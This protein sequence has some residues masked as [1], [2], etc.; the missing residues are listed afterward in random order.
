M[1]DK[2]QI[3]SRLENRSAQMRLI[4]IALFA[5]FAMAITACGSDDDDPAGTPTPEDTPVA[6]DDGTSPDPCQLVRA[7]DVQDALDAVIARPEPERV[8][9]LRSC[10]YTREDGL[11]NVRIQTMVTTEEAF[12]ELIRDS[13][14]IL[15]VEAD[16]VPA[17]G[18]ESYFLGSTLLT[19]KGTTH[20]QILPETEDRDRQVARQLMER[21]VSRLP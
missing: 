7:A 10:R 11:E 2:L 9:H 3:Q 14:I 21:A 18:D 19:R 1:L 15:D 13:A 4:L 17:L 6:I 5:A 8:E 16:P 12:E 20:I